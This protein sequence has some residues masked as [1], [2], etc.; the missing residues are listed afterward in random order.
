[1]IPVEAV[2][3]SKSFGDFKAVE[4]LSFSVHSGDIYGF[5]GPNGAGKSTTIRMLLG[6]IRPTAGEI[7]FFGQSISSGQ[8][9]YLKRVGA[10]VEKPDFYKYLSARSNLKILG[11]MSGADVS[12]VQLDRV[13]ELVGLTGRDKEPVK[14]YSHGMKQRLGLAQALLHDPEL[15]ILDEPTTGL[16]PQGI[17]DLRN[18]TL[19]LSASGK[20]VFMSSHILSEVELIASRMVIISKGRAVAEGKVNELLDS[21]DLLVRF[22]F[23]DIRKA[24]AL[25][26]QSEWKSSFTETLDSEVVFRLNRNEVEKLNTWFCSVD[27]APSGINAKRKLED[28]FMK[29]TR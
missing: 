1:M 16:D 23:N 27:C 4:Q 14:N 11:T 25:V 18:L 5:L 20:T 9:D 3:L 13:I 2:N 29:L 12:S 21:N 15:I 8:V 6:L 28:Y 10:I 26:Y 19:Q 17:V 22:S 24:I 7:R